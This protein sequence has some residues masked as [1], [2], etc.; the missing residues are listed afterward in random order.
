MNDDRS[1]D[2]EKQLSVSR[3]LLAMLIAADKADV[4]PVRWTVNVSGWSHYGEI[5]TPV[6]PNPHATYGAWVEFLGLQIGRNPNWA[7]GTCSADPGVPLSVRLLEE[8]R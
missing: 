2:R 6:D 5:D 4:P 8:G 1:Y 7:S 3:A